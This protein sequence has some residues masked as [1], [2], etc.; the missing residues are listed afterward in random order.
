[1]WEDVEQTKMS[2]TWVIFFERLGQGDAE[3]EDPE[4]KATFGLNRLLTIED[5]LTNHFISQTEGRF[6]GLLVNGKSPAKGDTVRIVI[7]KW[8]YD[9]TDLGEEDTQ[10]WL[11]IFADIDDLPGFIE[12]AD[13]DAIDPPLAEGTPYVEVFS[14]A[15]GTCEFK[16]ESNG[17]DGQIAPGDLLR[18]N[19]TQ[20]GSDYAGKNYEIVL[21]WEPLQ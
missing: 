11:N 2:R 15:A 19:C 17:E 8:K 16:K 20:I 5:D 13:F 18:I 14:P 21:S 12:L 1:M 7:E 10:Q 9:T 6:A 4:M 3:A